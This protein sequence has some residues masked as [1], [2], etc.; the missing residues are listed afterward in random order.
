MILPKQRRGAIQPVTDADTRPLPVEDARERGAARQYQHSITTA[1]LRDRLRAVESEIYADERRRNRER[2]EYDL[3][4]SQ[5]DQIIRQ[6]DDEEA[7]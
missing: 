1:K 3:L 2:A 7:I 6:Y 4:Q 5:A